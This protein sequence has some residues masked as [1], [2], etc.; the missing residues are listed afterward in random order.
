MIV[1]RLVRPIGWVVSFACLAFFAHHLWIVG[2]ATPSRPARDTAVFI[3]LSATAYA[4]AVAV[5]A[6]S[7]VAMLRGACGNMRALAASYLLGQFAKYLP[8]NVFQYAARHGLGIRAGASHRDLIAAALTE[9]YLL[10]CACTAVC[11]ISGSVVL[12]K[13]A[14]DWPELPSELAAAPVIAAFLVLLPARFLPHIEWL[15]RLRARAVTLSFA[16]YVVFFH[17]FGG[18]YWLCLSWFSPVL[19][20]PYS[21][22]GASAV[23]W[24]A[25][26]LIPGAPSGAG[27]R[28]AALSLGTESSATAAEVAASIVLFR[29]VTLLGDFLAFLMGWA[30]GRS[31]LLRRA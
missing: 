5:L 18:L 7:W 14:P 21:A 1:S 26:F 29:L 12:A 8:G 17:V 25:G 4:G 24:L 19:A 16:G 31:L 3:L 13:I 15:P 10:V 27:V 28:E 23:A 22:I 9:A 2:F 20:E 30:S 6:L 11:L